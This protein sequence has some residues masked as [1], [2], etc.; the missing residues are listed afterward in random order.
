MRIV[1]ITQNEPFYLV[2]NLRYLIK[3]MP[4]HSKI[5]GCVVA[6]AS[7]FGKKESFLKKAFKTYKIFGLRFFIRYSIK[8]LFSLLNF[9]NNLKLL[10]K[11]NKIEIIKIDKNI[12][13]SYSVSTI[14]NYEPDILIS[15]L[16]N[17]IFKKPI[18]ELAPK[19]CLNLH[20]ALLPKYRGLMPCF[21]VLKNNESYTGVS[22]F[23]VD[24]GI[25]SGKIISQRKVE[26]NDCTLEELIIKT[27]KIGMKLIIESVEKIKNDSVVIIPNNDNHKTYFS[28]PKK[29]DVKIFKEMGKKFY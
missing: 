20:S 7:P 28:F 27:K 10:L 17:Q 4:D 3:N 29:E 26:I 23:Y 14:K 19:G 13:S 21:W 5:V 25:D 22:V 1:I 24:E 8:F 15:I 6:K 2:D 16:G 18:I 12:N 11:K 9:N